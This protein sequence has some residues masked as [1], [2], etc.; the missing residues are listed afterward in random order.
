MQFVGLTQQLE[1]QQSSEVED[2]ELNINGNEQAT[3]QSDPNSAES[4]AP[5]QEQ[6][7]RSPTEPPRNTDTIS[8]EPIRRINAS[9]SAAPKRFYRTFWRGLAIRTRSLHREGGDRMML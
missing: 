1:A 5:I 3:V 4:E 7:P 6:N 9:T 2:E 8:Y